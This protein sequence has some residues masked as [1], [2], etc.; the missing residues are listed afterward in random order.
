LDAIDLEL[1]SMVARQEIN[2][3]AAAAQL[4]LRERTVNERL[5]PGSP[6]YDWS[7]VRFE[8][9]LLSLSGRIERFLHSP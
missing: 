8:E 7:L 5:Q 3:P 2:L 4:G 6:L 9:G 1:L